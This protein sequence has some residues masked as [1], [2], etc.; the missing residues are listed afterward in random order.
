MKPGGYEVVWTDAD[1]GR[2]KSLQCHWMTPIHVDGYLYGSQRPA[3]AR[4]P[5]CAASSWRPAR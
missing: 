5:S 1:K 4:T 3:H 2:D